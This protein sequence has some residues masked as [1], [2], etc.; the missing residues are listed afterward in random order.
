[1]PR[2]ALEA[3]G[4]HGATCSPLQLKA[5]CSLPCWL[6]FSQTEVALLLGEHRARKQ[7]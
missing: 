4:V 2:P 7:L 6:W 3:F 5:F 1:M